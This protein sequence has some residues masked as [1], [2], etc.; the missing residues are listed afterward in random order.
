MNRT[1]RDRD[2]GKE[3]RRKMWGGEKETEW[4][5]RSSSSYLDTGLTG[6]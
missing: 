2:G 4:I 6:F 5:G 1:G 3:G